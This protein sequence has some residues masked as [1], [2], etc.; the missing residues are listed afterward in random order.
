VKKL[1]KNPRIDNPYALAHHILNKKGS[2]FNLAMST[3]KAIMKIKKAAGQCRKQRQAIRGV[4]GEHFREVS[5][6]ISENPDARDPDAIAATVLRKKYEASQGYA[7]TQ[8]GKR[9]FPIGS[10]QDKLLHTRK[11]PHSHVHFVNGEKRITR[12]D[13][14]KSSKHSSL[15][16]VASLESESGQYATYFL[17]AGDEVNGRG[18]GVTEESIPKN[19]RTFKGMPFVITSSEYIEGSPYGKIYDH[20]STEHFDVLGIAPLGSFDINNVELIKQFQNFFRIGEIIDVFYK[21]GVWMCI[22]KKDTKYL[23]VPWPPFCSPAIYKLDPHEEDGKI[24][25]WFGLH[26]AGLDQRPA[27]GK[28]AILKAVC[29]GHLGVCGPQL[30]KSASLGSCKIMKLKNIIHHENAKLAAQFREEDHPRDEEGK[31]TCK[32]CGKSITTKDQKQHVEEHQTDIENSIKQQY[33]HLKEEFIKQQ[34]Q[35]ATQIRDKHVPIVNKLLGDLKELFPDALEISGRVKTVHNMVEKVGRKPKDYPDVEKLEDVSGLRI[36]VKDGIK[37]VRD[38][39][40]QIKDS[41]KFDIKSE[42]NYIDNPKGGYRSYHFT[43]K[44]KKTGMISELQIRTK[45]QDIWANYVHDR[46]YKMPH[47]VMQRLGPRLNQVHEYVSDLAQYLYELDSG[48]VNVKKPDCPEKIMEE[49][50]GCLD[51]N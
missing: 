36:V 8:R 40:K 13:S 35:K 30:I 11:L 38:T 47:T 1:K 5:K 44:D 9:K 21:D 20:P 23:H 18:W 6:K 46:I 33:P 2:R 43:L 31:F 39:I 16:R 32:E 42:D 15:A 27:Y 22:V 12:Y 25:K 14:G 45:N 37:I 34:V 7:T 24:T 19:I 48:N 4:S 50:G 29:N 26:L 49:I 41:G 3:A 28:I 17:L 10:P 51:L